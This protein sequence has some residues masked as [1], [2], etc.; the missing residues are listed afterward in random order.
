M[1]QYPA[2]TLAWYAEFLLHINLKI[3]LRKQGARL[4]FKI[5]LISLHIGPGPSTMYQTI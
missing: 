1:G 5:A 4:K 3:L 2:G